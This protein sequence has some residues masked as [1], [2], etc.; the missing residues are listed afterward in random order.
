MLEKANITFELS[1]PQLAFYKENL[2]WITEPGDFKV[3]IGGSSDG[4]KLE[5]NFE[6]K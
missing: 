5:G 3:M 1:P 2:G 4:I 6:L